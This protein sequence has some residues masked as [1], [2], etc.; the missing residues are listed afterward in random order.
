MEERDRQE[1]NRDEDRRE[2]ASRNPVA[3]KEPH[4]AF[5]VYDESG[6]DVSLLRFIPKLSPLERLQLMERHAR[7]TQRLNE[8]GRAGMEG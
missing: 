5:G 6:V 4:L 7:D 2:M 1:P 3:A 8:Y